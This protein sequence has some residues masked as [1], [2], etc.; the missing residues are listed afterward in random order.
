MKSMDPVGI[1]GGHMT[2]EDLVVSLQLVGA[3]TELDAVPG[4]LLMN[5]GM[6]KDKALVA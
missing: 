1:V 3:S 6:Q 2:L 5:S 4:M